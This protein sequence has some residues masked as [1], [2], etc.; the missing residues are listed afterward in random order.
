[1]VNGKKGRDLIS[2]IVPV[3]NIIDYLPRC[4]DSICAQTYSNLEI[5]LV[6]DGSDDGTEKLVDEFGKK[7]ARIR[8]FHKENGG[9][10]SA[11][12]LGIANARGKWIGFVDSDDF[13]D[14]RMYEELMDCVEQYGVSIAQASRDEIDAD[15]KKL[16]DVCLPPDET[17]VCGAEMFLRELLLHRGDSSFCTKL[18]EKRLFDERR[19]PEGV[20]NEDFHLLV[21]MLQEVSEIAVIPDQYYH[22]FY[23]IGSNTRK[24]TKEEF[25]RVYVDIV[26]NADMVERLVKE[27]Y[28]SLLKEVVRF[29]LYQRLDYMLHI[30]VSGMTGKDEFYLAVKRYLRLHIVDTVKNPY[31][32]IK[33][34][35]YLLLLTIAPK[36]V[37]QVHEWKMERTR[38][39][40]V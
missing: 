32:T 14:S 31:L 33:N 11:R 27:K 39:K 5:I 8:V 26:N 21:D 15:G 9:S 36:S 12:N 28:S 16:P 19:F 22:V 37:R 18:T 30:P 3:Y 34:K 17:Y 2:V 6:D 20:L 40:T 29:G 23:R 4:V 35:A 38:R 13:I 7:D 24:K 10:S 1:M 25:S